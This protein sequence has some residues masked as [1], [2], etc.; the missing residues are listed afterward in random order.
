MPKA[1]CKSSLGVLPQRHFPLLE[2]SLHMWQSLSMVLFINVVMK[3]LYL[4]LHII[5]DVL[6]C[7]Q[8]NFQWI[9]DEACPRWELVHVD[10]RCRVLVDIYQFLLFSR[11][12]L[13]PLMESY[14]LR[15]AYQFLNFVCSFS[16]DVLQFNQIN[17]HWIH[18]EACPRWELVHGHLRVL[19]ANCLTFV[20]FF[21]Y[22][23]YVM[24][25]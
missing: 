12:C 11:L 4:C 24:F 16:F 15:G 13:V 18:D 14:K 5:L 9:H 17:S 23:P 6:Q 8:I 20:N 10:L 2:Y 3:F 25:L 21:Y 19:V 7:S 1:L 22:P